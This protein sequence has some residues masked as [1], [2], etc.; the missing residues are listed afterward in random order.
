MQSFAD[1]SANLSG[2]SLSPWLARE[3]E[4]TRRLADSPT[5]YHAVCSPK[6]SDTSTPNTTCPRLAPPLPAS[7]PPPF[8]SPFLAP[9]RS[10]ER[11]PSTASR[12]EAT[13]DERV[14][15]HRPV[16]IPIAPPRARAPGAVIV[17]VEIVCVLSQ[18]DVCTVHVPRT[19]AP[20]PA[21]ITSARGRAVHQSRLVMPRHVMSCNQ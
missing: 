8:C 19:H 11:T 13:N 21:A 7:T 16:H 6:R 4:Q 17:L 18:T 20:S 14:S 10:A 3:M 15:V 9:S 1:A 2:D 5:A 12:A